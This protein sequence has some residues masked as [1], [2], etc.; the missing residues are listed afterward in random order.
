VGQLESLRRVI[1]RHL[2][3]TGSPKARRVLANW[4]SESQAFC[5]IAPVEAVA[6][7]ESLFDGTAIEPAA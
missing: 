6:R 2:E 4:G 1:D 5:R 3:A 7:L